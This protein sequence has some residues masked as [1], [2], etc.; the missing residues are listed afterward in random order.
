M[1]MLSSFAYCDGRGQ[2][3]LIT[4]KSNCKGIANALELYASDNAG[5][6][7]RSLQRLRWAGY[8]KTIPTCPSTG[9]VTY[10]NYR[11]SQNPDHFSF[12]CVGNNHAQAY[13]GLPQPYDNYPRYNAQESTMTDHP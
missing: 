3:N 5:N 2:R 11:V 9:E 12:A 6:Y 10:T 8:L 13:A 1:A 7:P 4:C